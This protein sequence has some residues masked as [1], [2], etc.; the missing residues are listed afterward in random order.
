MVEI[1]KCI[2]SF[3][4]GDCSMPGCISFGVELKLLTP[5]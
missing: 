4:A 1:Y 3:I 5:V 2:Y